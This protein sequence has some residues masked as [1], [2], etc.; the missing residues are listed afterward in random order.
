[1]RVRRFQLHRRAHLERWQP[2]RVGESQIGVTENGETAEPIGCLSVTF[3][4]PASTPRATAA[5]PPDPRHAL[6]TC[7]TRGC[8]RGRRGSGPSPVTGE[9][10]LACRSRVRVEDEPIESC[11]RPFHS[12]R[13]AVGRQHRDPRHRCAVQMRRRSFVNGTGRSCGRSS[14]S[15]VLTSCPYGVRSCGPCV[16]HASPSAGGPTMFTPRR[17]ATAPI[18]S[19]SGSSSG[20]EKSG[21]AAGCPASAKNCSHPGGAIRHR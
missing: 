10:H 7:R 13:R 8:N 6:G 11:G 5:P 9:S 16:C 3:P 12:K 15:C 20:G 18:L 19:K 21:S 1:M 4:C 2:E 17:A 14:G